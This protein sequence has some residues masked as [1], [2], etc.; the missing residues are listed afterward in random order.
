MENV[1]MGLHYLLKNPEQHSVYA[2][3]KFW[4]QLQPIDLWF[5]I[6]PP[7]I[8]KKTT[9]YSKPMLDLDKTEI[10]KRIKERE[11][12][13]N[14]MKNFKEKYNSRVTKEGWYTRPH[15]P[16]GLHDQE[17]LTFEV[18]EATT[19]TQHN[20]L[21]CSSCKINQRSASRSLL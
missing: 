12:Y 2:I 17:Q 9:N 15:S 18:L 1:K 8:E 5:L 13:I 10:L 7:T 14:M 11:T 19:L 6:I 3:D 20:S 4:Q 21:H 16:G